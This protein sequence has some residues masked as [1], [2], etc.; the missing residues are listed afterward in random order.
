MA[1]SKRRQSRARQNRTKSLRSQRFRASTLQPSASQ[2]KNVQPG[3]QYYDQL[4]QMLTRAESETQ[5]DSPQAY[6]RVL[7]HTE[8]IIKNLIVMLCWPIN[9]EDNDIAKKC[10]I[11]QKL[12]AGTLYNICNYNAPQ[13]I[14]STNILVFH[15]G[16]IPCA[17]NVLKVNDRRTIQ[18]QDAQLHAARLLAVLAQSFGNVFSSEMVKDISNA[19]NTNDKTKKVINGLLSFT[20]SGN[21]QFLVHR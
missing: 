2:L 21:K 8:P 9:S 4:I 20:S 6:Q 16:A 14:N 18:A 10:A 1:C 11:I 15:N 7:N 3:A 19:S 12:A 17:I 5:R 13:H